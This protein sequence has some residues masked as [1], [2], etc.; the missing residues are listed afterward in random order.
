MTVNSAIVSLRSEAIREELRQ[1]SYIKN[2]LSA[3]ISQYE[4]RLAEAVETIEN[5]EAELK[6]LENGVNP[7]D[8]RI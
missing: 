5:L 3:V 7:D 2:Q 4:G 1:W 8:D 6:D